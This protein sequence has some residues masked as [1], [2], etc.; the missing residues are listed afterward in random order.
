MPTHNL[1]RIEEYFKEDI[2]MFGYTFDSYSRKIE[3]IL[4]K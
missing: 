4:N 2:E 3:Q 1:L